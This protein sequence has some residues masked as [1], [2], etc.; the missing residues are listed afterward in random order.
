MSKG[1]AAERQVLHTVQGRFACDRDELIGEG[2][3]CI[4]GGHV[5]AV[6]G[7]VVEQMLGLVEVEFTRRIHEAQRIVDRVPP[8]AAEGTVPA[9]CL[10]DGAVGLL[11]EQDERT[12]FIAHITGAD[13]VLVPGRTVDDLEVVEIGFDPRH[14]AGVVLHAVALDAGDPCPVRLSGRDA[15]L[16]VAALCLNGDTAHISAVVVDIEVAELVV[17]VEGRGIER[18]ADLLPAGDLPCA[19]RQASCPRRPDR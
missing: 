19:G 18:V 17:A 15:V 5:F 2:C 3:F 1:D 11:E 7:I 14:I 6:E 4:C 10:R 9:G 8:A 12:V 13:D 16:A